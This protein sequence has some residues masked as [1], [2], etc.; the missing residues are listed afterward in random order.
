MPEN[1]KIKAV[2]NYLE[3]QNIRVSRVKITKDGTNMPCD[4]CFC[5]TENR[6]HAKI[7]EN[8]LD[9]ASNEGFYR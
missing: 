4:A 3:E 6:I 7:N 1:E 8:D 5:T 2:K 9:K